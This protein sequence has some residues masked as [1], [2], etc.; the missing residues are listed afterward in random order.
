LSDMDK[1]SKWTC[2]YFIRFIN[3]ILS[4][5]RRSS[6]K[7]PSKSEYALIAFWVALTIKSNGFAV[8]SESGLIALWV[9]LAATQ[10]KLAANSE[11]SS[12]AFWIALAASLNELAAQSKMH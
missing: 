3:C 12:I 11:C 1:S 7:L 8:E 2:N 6:N 4:W 9:A 5:T 10:N